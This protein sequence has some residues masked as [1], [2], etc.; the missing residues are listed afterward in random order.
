MGFP[1]K[2]VKTN[3]KMKEALTKHVDCKHEDENNHEDESY[4]CDTFEHVFNEI[5][6]LIDHYGETGHN[7]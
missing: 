2:N 3:F 7:N 1:V 6:D 4:P 5:E